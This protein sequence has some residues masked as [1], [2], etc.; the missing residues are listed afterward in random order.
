LIATVFVSH[1]AQD[2]RGSRSPNT[3]ILSSRADYH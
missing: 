2:R 3:F 1:L